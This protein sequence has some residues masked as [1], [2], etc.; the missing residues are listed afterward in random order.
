MLFYDDG[1]SEKIGWK[2]AGHMWWVDCFASTK[3]HWRAFLTSLNVSQTKESIFSVLLG[4][5]LNIFLLQKSFR[6]LAK[7]HF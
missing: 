6:R 2:G 5:I 7:A 3:A 4:L 1:L